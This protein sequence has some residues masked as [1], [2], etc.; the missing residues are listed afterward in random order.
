MFCP[1][2][3]NNVR[4]GA[5]FC[6]KCGYEFPKASQEVIEP[7]PPA[8]PQP[9]SL[10][11]VG[12]L[13]LAVGILLVAFM[14]LPWYRIGVDSVINEANSAMR[15]AG[16]IDMEIPRVGNIGLSVTGIGDALG[17][18]AKVENWIKKA[19][20][21]AE[22]LFESEGMESLES[23]AIAS[24]FYRVF[25]FIWVAGIVTFIAGSSISIFTKQDGAIARAGSVLCAVAAIIGIVVALFAASRIDG[26]L[27][28]MVSSE[29][30]YDLVPL[31]FKGFF[32]STI[33]P[34]GTLACSC[35]SFVLT[36]LANGRE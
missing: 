16:E 34:Y 32:K 19:G 31:N 1:H 13:R 2:C 14:F 11:S 30:G 29:L 5:A 8:S 20:E 24:F 12:V 36:F 28:E 7:K 35:L 27:T 25:E 22:L 15:S 9:L 6:P 26:A 18:V 10:D 21:D 17:S 3:G 4:E 33:A 23:V